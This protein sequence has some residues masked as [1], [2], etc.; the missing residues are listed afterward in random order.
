MK[1]AKLLLGLFAAAAIFSSCSGDDDA[2]SS[3]SAPLEGKWFYS[4]SGIAASGQEVLLDYDEHQ[5]GCSKD[6]V[7]FV[8]G[9]VFN[10]VDYYTSEC[11]F[12]NDASTWTRSGNTIT[13][14]TGAN[15]EIATIVVLDNST[16]KITSTD[17]EMPGAQFVSVYT[18]Q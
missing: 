3:T 1:N 9:G 11:A 4:K 14:G 13:I 16:L 2:G 10:D 5:S 15:A 7:E 18:R 6:Y 12:T 8:A 17:E